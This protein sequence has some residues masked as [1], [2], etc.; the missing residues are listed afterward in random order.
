MDN[1]SFK[2]IQKNKTII[3]D[4]NTEKIDINSNLNKIKNENEKN[5]KLCT[6]IA[7]SRLFLHKRNN[8]Y[9][10]KGCLKQICISPRDI[11]TNVNESY[12]YFQKIKKKQRNVSIDQ[13]IQKCKKLYIDLKVIKI[14]VMKYQK[15]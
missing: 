2:N 4:Y 7:L 6:D 12:D 10:E 9:T 1:N 11:V 3:S 5:E 8:Y 13:L 14:N 15:V